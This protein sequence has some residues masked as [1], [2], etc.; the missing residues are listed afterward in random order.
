MALPA[1]STGVS[2]NSGLI[3][4]VAG[5]RY[6]MVAGVIRNSGS[7]NYWQPINDS[8]H[9][10][11]NIDSVTTDTSAI[12]IDHS[13]LA[14]T[15]NV[16]F[17]AVV[18]ETLA[19]QGFTVGA[20]S[21]P[22]QAILWLGSGAPLND[23]VSY[24]GS[25]WTTSKSPSPFTISSFTGGVL[26]LTHRNLGSNAQAVSLV[27]RGNTYRC[28]IDEGSAFDPS[29]TGVKFI[30]PATNTVVSSPDTNM[31]VLVS[32]GGGARL[33]GLN[34]QLVDT[35]TFPNSNIWLLGIFEL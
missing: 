34:P 10:P 29:T 25:A 3:T 20:S 7:P 11:Q 26:T 21:T 4:G 8:N 35:T 22:T 1:V 18:D 5:K 15:K 2:L 30:D 31:K 13:S 24:N 27:P 14:A 33:S 9:A 23:Y 28:V 19:A 32:R 12:T 17:I 16:A 6:G